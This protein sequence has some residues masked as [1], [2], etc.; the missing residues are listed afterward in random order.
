MIT[1]T[2]MVEKESYALERCYTVVYL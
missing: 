2:L 1:A